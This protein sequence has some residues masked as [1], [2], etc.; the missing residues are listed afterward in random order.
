MIKNKIDLH[1]HIDGSVRC[2]TVYELSRKYNIEPECHMTLDEI[3]KSMMIPE[4]EYDP[5][6][7]TFEAPIRIMQT[8]EG[9]QRATKELIERLENDGLIY[10]ELRFAPQY[11]LQKGLSQE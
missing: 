1:L 11:H 7:I 4:G 3:R 9:I 8:H 10:A 2:E 5:D 6:F